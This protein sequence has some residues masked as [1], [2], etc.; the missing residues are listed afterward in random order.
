MPIIRVRAKW[1]AFWVERDGV[2][3]DWGNLSRIATLSWDSLRGSRRSRSFKAFFM[4][5]PT[6][7]RVREIAHLF[8]FSARYDQ[9]DGKNHE[10]SG[11]KPHVNPKGFEGS[12]STVWNISS[13]EIETRQHPNILPG[14]VCCVSFSGS[15]SQ[16]IAG[17]KTGRR[18]YG[19]GLSKRPSAT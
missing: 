5:A 3:V 6:R 9:N 17:E 10:R 11:K 1:F 18:V 12:P 19:M 4:N 13:S 15:C 8:G 2:P 7:K 14:A 16:Y